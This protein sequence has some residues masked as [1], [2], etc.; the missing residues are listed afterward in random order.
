MRKEELK[1]REGADFWASMGPQPFGCGRLVA[2]CRRRS[3]VCFNGAATFRLRKVW[4][5]CTNWPNGLPLQWGRNLSVA[6]GLQSLPTLVKIS[7][8]SMGPQP[9]GCGRD[10]AR[11]APFHAKFASM[12]PQPFGC[13]RRNGEAAPR[14]PPLLQWG[15]NLSVAEGP[16]RSWRAS[17]SNCFNGAATFRLR[18][19]HRPAHRPAP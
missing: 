18:K 4:G 13:G 10:V 5:G 8:A 9:F 1:R 11:V 17:P 6:E 7:I 14:L 15:R 19:D 12:G 2:S 3:E 16:L